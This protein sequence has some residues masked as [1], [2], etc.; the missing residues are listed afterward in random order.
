MVPS[1]EIYYVVAFVNFRFPV[2]EARSP[3]CRGND[4]RVD[5]YFTVL[6]LIEMPSLLVRSMVV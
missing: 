2:R 3:G 5:D 4:G 6:Q 1:C